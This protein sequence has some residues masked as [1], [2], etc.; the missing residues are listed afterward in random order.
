[1]WSE[2]I[3]DRALLCWFNLCKS[4]GRDGGLRS[5]RVRRLRLLHE[6]L[7]NLFVRVSTRACA[8][9]SGVDRRSFFYFGLAFSRSE[10]APCCSTQVLQRC[11]I[12]LEHDRTR[13]HFNDWSRLRSDI[14]FVNHSGDTT[15][16]ARTGRTIRSGGEE[17]LVCGSDKR[18]TLPHR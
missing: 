4:S 14:Y 2:S 17:S 11:R 5:S 12:V 16:T 10:V 3:G 13:V 6:G 7:S 8:L 9:G 1:R 18:T 15:L